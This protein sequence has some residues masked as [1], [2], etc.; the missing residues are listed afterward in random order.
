MVDSNYLCDPWARAYPLR[1]RDVT[2]CADDT[3]LT[4][5][6]WSR[7]EQLMNYMGWRNGLPFTIQSIEQ[8]DSLVEALG[9]G[10]Y[11]LVE[12]CGF[13]VIAR[14][15]LTLIDSSWREVDVL[16]YVVVGPDCGLPT[17]D[18]STS[19]RVFRSWYWPNR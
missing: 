14:T 1:E 9:E 19:C 16:H 5:Y 10:Y 3:C 18:T 15:R 4:H 17:G 12:G 11:E 13:T 6:L 7:R 2:I 8:S